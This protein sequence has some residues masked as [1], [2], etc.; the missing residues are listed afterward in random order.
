MAKKL[1]PAPITNGTAGN[2]AAILSSADM[3][4][5]GSG[6]RYATVN[7]YG[8]VQFWRCKPRYSRSSGL[9]ARHP[10]SDEMPYNLNRDKGVLFGL[11]TIQPR[12]VKLSDIAESV[13]NQF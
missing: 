5:N 11:P 3:A 13:L 8:K 12:L 9:W 6:F 2:I 1:S 7:G 10:D 4:K